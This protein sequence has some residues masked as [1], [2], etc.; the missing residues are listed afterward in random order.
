MDIT[1]IG[2]LVGIGLCAYGWYALH[3][4]QEKKREEALDNVVN[5]VETLRIAGTEEINKMYEEFEIEYALE[6]S[7]HEVKH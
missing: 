4:H 2:I 5:L 6:Q 1:G 7:K 3:K